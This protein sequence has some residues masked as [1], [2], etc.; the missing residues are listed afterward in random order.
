[1]SYQNILTERV[2]TIVIIT[3]NRPDKRNAMSPKLNE[4]MR[5]TVEHLATDSR[6]G[7][8]VLTGAGDSFNAGFLDAWLEGCAVADCL[9]AGVTCGT[10]STRGFG[11]T[12]TQPT[13]AELRSAL[14]AVW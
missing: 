10:L 3:M 13:R 1:M 8:L 6:C 5:A 11:G 14:E 9:R 2:E 12:A 4:E 7:V